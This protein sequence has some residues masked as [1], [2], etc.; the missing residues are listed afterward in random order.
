MCLPV[1]VSDIS[2]IKSV[3]EA[4]VEDNV[5]SADFLSTSIDGE[6][7]AILGFR[8]GTSVSALFYQPM[9]NLCPMHLHR[10]RRTDIFFP[11]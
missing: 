5:S 8:R 2:H 10:V 4:L 6:A 7:L 9:G 3:G 1:R 11:H